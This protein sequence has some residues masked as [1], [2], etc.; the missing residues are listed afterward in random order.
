M[1]G[2]HNEKLNNNN[3]GSG[4]SSSSSKNKK[5]KLNEIEIDSKQIE[6]KLT[7]SLSPK[8]IIVLDTIAGVGP[9]SMLLISSHFYEKIIVYAND[10]N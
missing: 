1:I 4:G 10:L 8:S 7:S 6:Q 9:L 5:R 3:G 2:N